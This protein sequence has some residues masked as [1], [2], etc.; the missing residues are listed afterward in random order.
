[1]CCYV[2]QYGHPALTRRLFIPLLFLCRM[3]KEFKSWKECLGLR[4]VKVSG[5]EKLFCAVLSGTWLVGVAAMVP[6]D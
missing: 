5:I 2:S 4:E 3:K 6:M 1:M